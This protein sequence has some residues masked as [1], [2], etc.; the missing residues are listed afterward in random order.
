V[1][2]IVLCAAMFVAVA[3]LAV[4]RPMER[5]DSYVGKEIAK[6]AEEQKATELGAVTVGD[7]QGW[8]DRVTV[9][10]RKD[11]YVARAAGSSFM[12]PG[13][14]QFKNGQAGLGALLLGGDIAANVGAILGAY[15]LLPADLRI[16]RFNYLTEPVGNI[17]T[18][19]KSHSLLEYLPSVGVAFGGHLLDMA[20]RA[21]AAHNARY[22]ARAR[23]ESG[24][25][26]LSADAR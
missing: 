17:E 16:D 12:L 10:A 13:L 14:G 19:W 5:A 1:R 3:G 4:A 6:I 21:I 9:A 15:F 8:R 22:V 24:Q 7:L 2:R 20:L 18:L 23:I 25:V 11:A 26:T